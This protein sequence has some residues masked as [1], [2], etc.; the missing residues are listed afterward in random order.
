MESE[1]R[2][3]LAETE[4]AEVA[5]AQHAVADDFLDPAKALPNVNGLAAGIKWKDGRP[6]GEPAMLVLVDHKVASD[7][8]ASGQAIPK[9][10]GGMQTDVLAIG[11]PTILPARVRSEACG[12]CCSKRNG[13]SAM[14]SRSPSISRTSAQT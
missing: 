13:W 14:R 3:V 4:A 7:E 5:K 9:K 11:S 12:R 6:T 10:L 8:L 1:S 2:M